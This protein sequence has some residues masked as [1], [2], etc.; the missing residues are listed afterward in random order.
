MNGAT[1]GRSQII[2]TVHSDTDILQYNPNTLMYLPL[3]LGHDTT[4][5]QLEVDFVN[6]FEQSTMRFSSLAK[7]ALVCL[8]FK[9]GHSCSSS[10][11]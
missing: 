1:H 5:N 9:E 7:G 10:C 4:L 6:E 3:N 11:E 2:A 8:H